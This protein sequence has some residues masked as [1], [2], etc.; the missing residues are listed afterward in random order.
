VQ[1]EAQLP[2]V[3]FAYHVPNL[4]SPDGPALEVLSSLLA[5]GKSSRLYRRLVYEK[6]IARDAGADFDLTSIDPGVFYV[7]AQPL[8]GKTAKQVEDALLEEIVAVQRAP[9]G[10]R[11]LDKVKNGLASDTV[12]A[13]DS[14]FYQAMLLGQYEMAGDWRALDAYLPGIR[15]VGPADVQ[16][17]ATTYLTGTN[18]TVA[19]LDPLP[20]TG[21]R[22]P[23][24]EAPTGMVH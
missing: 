6:R 14:L 4:H 24:E 8:P 7:Y 11:E 5:G 3:A 12:F 15:A 20:I 17:V 16:R 18:R 2:Y 13:Q 22:A 23:I 9:V 19:L 1:R 21:K 10:G